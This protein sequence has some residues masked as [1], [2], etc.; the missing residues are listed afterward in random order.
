MPNT[1]NYIKGTVIF[2][3][4]ALLGACNKK[5][6][7]IKPHNVLFEDQQFGTPAGYT[8]ATIAN[9]NSL[10]T[11]GATGGYDYNWFNLSEFRGNNVRTIDNTSS[12][13]LTASQDVDAFNFTNSSSKDFGRSDAFWKA[14]YKALLGINIVLK[15]INDTESD[16]TIL[17]AKAEN[18]FL[19]AVVYFNLIRLYG[20]PYY[21]SPTGNL[22]V[23][24]ILKPIET[25][26]D[27]PT[28]ATVEETYQ[29]IISDLTESIKNFRYTRVNSFASKYAAYALLSRVYLYM[30]GP[31]AQ[32]NTQYAQ[33][34]TRYADS[35]IINGG[36]SLLQ[37]AAYT[38]YYNNSNQANAETIWAVN[39]DNIVTSVPTLLYQ[40]TG[41][42]TGSTSYSTGQ[43]KP[44]PDLLNL[45]SAA[46]LRLSFYVKDK[47]PG[48]NTD[49]LSCRKYMYKYTAVYTS[50]APIHYLRLAEMYLNR[51]EARVKAGDNGGALSD[52]NIIRQRAGL[53]PASGLSGQAL[54]DEILTQRRLELAFEGH[55]S[56][57]YFRNG[58]PMVRSYSSFNSAPL[59]IS[60]TDP[61]V[62]LRISDD[63]LIENGNITQNN[64]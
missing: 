1:T 33:L 43:V 6:D 15:H 19:R 8:K 23:S 25:A 44:S 7:E 3:T 62:V 48:N 47:Y 37:G 41:Q 4:W 11:S 12:A 42:Y 64:Q 22:G 34:A 51:A 20:R 31:F 30:S 35:V 39:H 14:S 45:M 38:A 56:Y 40:P 54:F 46:D 55:N 49:T 59:T 50:N 32:P 24:L 21:Q 52:V 58:L 60:P 28:R 61:K 9:Y 29:Q 5:L 36:Y 13:N 18:L 63:I 2:L 53:L 27:K 16:S 26:A 17:Q 57:D 10:T